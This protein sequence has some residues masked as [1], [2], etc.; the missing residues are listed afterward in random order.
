MSPLKF[1]FAGGLSARVTMIL[2]MDIGYVGENSVQ[3][4]QKDTSRIEHFALLAFVLLVVVWI[5][6]RYFKSRRYIRNQ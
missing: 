4:L 2:M 5:I 3:V 1:L 6:V